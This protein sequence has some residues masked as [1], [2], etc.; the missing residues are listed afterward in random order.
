MKNFYLRPFRPEDAEPMALLAN[1]AKISE[2]LRDRFSYPYTI[3]DAQYFIQNIA[4]RFGDKGII[5]AIEVDGNFAGCISVEEGQ[6]VYR[7]SA[8]LGYWLGEP[9]WGQGIMA[10]AVRQICAEAFE[11]LDIVRIQAEIFARNTGSRKVVEKCGFTL[12]GI[13]EKSVYKR[14]ELLD[15]CMYALI[16]EGV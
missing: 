9:Y 3:E 15:A 10:D 16:K 1:N 11:K 13:L 2:N 5:Y 6:D 12:E 4:L 14:E 8:E 7:K